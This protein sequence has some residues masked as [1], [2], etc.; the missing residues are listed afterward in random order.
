MRSWVH[1]N[2]EIY[3]V[4]HKNQVLMTLTSQQ[5]LLAKKVDLRHLKKLLQ[6][7]LPEG[8]MLELVVRSEPDFISAE[9]Y[10]AT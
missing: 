5:A 8:S 9:E 4:V 6:K 3:G 10:F 7:V 2:Q 1:K